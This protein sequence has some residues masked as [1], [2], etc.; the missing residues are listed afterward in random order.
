MNLL[1]F[2]L[3]L[4]AGLLAAVACWLLRGR[5]IPERLTAVAV[6]A[7]AAGVIVNDVFTRWSHTVHQ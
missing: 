2:V 1:A 5:P 3:V 4:A 6:V 7:L